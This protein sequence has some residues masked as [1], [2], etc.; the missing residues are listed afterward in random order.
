MLL[1][2]HEF[3]QS[4]KVLIPKDSNG[5]NKKKSQKTSEKETSWRNSVKRSDASRFNGPH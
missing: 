4:A 3:H 2:Y 5:A 1:F